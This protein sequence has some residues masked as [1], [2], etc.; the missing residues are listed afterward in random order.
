MPAPNSLSV[1]SKLGLAFFALLPALVTSDQLPNAL[2]E[3]LLLLLV[4]CPSHLVP[5]VVVQQDL[6][7]V[8]PVL[9]LVV[10]AEALLGLLQLTIEGLVVRQLS[11]LFLRNVAL[12]DVFILLT[13]AVQSICRGLR[14]GEA[15]HAFIDDCPVADQ[16]SHQVVRL[17]TLHT[18]PH[19]LDLR[20]A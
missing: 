3:L 8:Y 9:G 6:P 15:L 7:Q 18:C 11:H 2:V 13:F 5:L 10:E 19:M 12:P 20:Q 16:F 1:L 17:A 4:D 14:G